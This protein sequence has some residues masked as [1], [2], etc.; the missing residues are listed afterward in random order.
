MP[1][2]ENCLVIVKGKDKTDSIESYTF[3]GNK[4][5][6]RYRGSP[7]VFCYNSSN[8]RLLQQIGIIDPRSVIF[9]VNGRVIS[10]I[11]RIQYF[12]E[13]YR[14]T[15]SNGAVRTIPKSEVILEANCL[16]D[17]NAR[18][19][20]DYFK[21]TA[22]ALSL[23]T[24]GGANI[25]RLQYDRISAVP[26]STILAKYLNSKLP[27]RPAEKPA[28][29]IYPF[30]LNQS[31]KQAVENAFSAPISIIQ[32]PPGTGK[33]QTILNILANAV[34]MGKTVAIVSN[35][36]SATQNVAE[37]LAKYDL[38]FLTAFLG[39][40]ANKER[41][42]TGQ[43]GS[44]PDM[45][46]WILEKSVQETLLRQVRSLSEELTAMLEARNRAAQVDRELLELKP[47]QFYFGKYYE[48]KGS[49]G[50]NTET[51]PRL[52]S[53]K[54]M[55]L[56][57]EYEAKGQKKPGFF[58]RI[59]LALR[60]GRGALT[61]FDQTPEAAIPFLQK[62]FYQARLRELRAEK[63][64]LEQK[65]RAYRFD[66]KIEELREES[67]KL[68]KAEL[69][70]R[71]P[72]RSPRQTFE[73][74]DFRGASEAFSAEYPVI[75]STTYAIKGTL[76]TD[77][78][79]DYLIVDE[80]SQVDL[81]TG[82]LAFSCA[83]NIVIVGDQKQLPNVLTQE[84]IRIADEIWNR[85]RFDERYH[86]AT[87]SMLASAA[88]IWRDAPSVLLREHYRCHPKIA[89]FFNQKFYNG[90][91]IVLT[92]D[93]GEKNVLS[94]YRTPP[95]NHA[96]GHLN[97][98]QIDIIRE[99]VLPVLTRQGFTDIGMITPY[100]DQAA[101]IRKQLGDN[102][103]VATVHKFQGREKE[104]IVLTSVDNVIG[105]FT[106][107]PNLLNVAVSRAVKSLTV[108][109]SDS[110][111]NRKTNYGDLARYM[112]YQNCQIVDSKVYSVFDMLYKCYDAQRRRYLKAHKRVSEYDSENLMYSV[113]EKVLAVP[114]FS[115]LDCVVH[116]SLA[117]LVKASDALTEKE[118][119]YAANPLTHLD[120]LLF[121][122]IDKSP[123]LVIE[124]DGTKYHMAGSRQAE[125]DARK[126]SI[127]EKCGV[128]IL[129]LR[130]DGSGEE[131]KIV[132]KLHELL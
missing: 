115:E 22:S 84:D 109:I 99:E 71:Y 127:L 82:V 114:D 48:A 66:A 20:F 125:R 8:V 11:E 35:N 7:K 74:K 1:I 73:Q 69:A 81:A 132:E 38:G 27:V 105:D 68:F 100:R 79:Y 123:V 65:L 47:E 117:T 36:N 49:S 51:F 40:L 45:G 63:E 86:F 46:S 16:Y 103:E 56:W 24:D 15:R 54:L 131:R 5:D 70:E 83:R 53:E 91:L 32:G 96:R 87:H 57:L 42:L 58:R 126:D 31:Q 95:G 14:V 90:E 72:W 33:T 23:K 122:R 44:Y 6:I 9:R 110:E 37:K 80:A 52:S 111:E 41:F 93:H 17:G 104:A 18:A 98:R 97:Q 12:G 34:R 30:G 62:Q 26:E 39:S 121:N 76:S 50:F 29:L 59:L 21:E 19:L 60:F 130:T 92:E 102:W 10:D 4:C 13:C 3:R 124:V 107:D 25:L 88:G 43:T 120:F 119:Q 94:M 112:E 75:L 28:A 78:F 129:R 85:H 106:D 118:R 101:A 128:P 116:S 61:L 67:M 77:F 113:I 108:V 55:S 2:P 89:E 64:R